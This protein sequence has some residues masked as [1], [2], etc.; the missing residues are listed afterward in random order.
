MSNEII[1]SIR[2]SLTFK[3]DPKLYLI[4][5]VFQEIKTMNHFT[6]KWGIADTIR[7]TTTMTG[8]SIHYKKLGPHI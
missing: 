5:L 3:K 2:Y 7:P 6:L 8:E 4:H 1:R